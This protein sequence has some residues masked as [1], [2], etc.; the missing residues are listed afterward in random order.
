MFVAKD[1]SPRIGTEIE[2]PKAD[3]LAG[4]YA[5]ELRDLLEQRGVLVFKKMHVDDEEQLQFAQTL[6]DILPQGDKGVM[7]VTLDAKQNPAAD[8]LRGNVFWHI[9]GFNDETPTKASM[10]SGRVLSETGGQT[11]IANTYAAWDDL[12]AERKAQLDG[13]M[14]IHNMR[15]AQLRIYPDPTPQQI[16]DW[17]TN[18]HDKRHPLVWTHQSGRKSLVLGSSTAYI[19]GLPEPE[20]KA[21]LDELE[22]W[23]TQP[24]FVYSHE[25][26][27]GDV[28]IWDNTGV[29]HRVVPFEEGSPR[30]MHRTTLVG[31]EMLA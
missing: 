13:L 16:D 14:V 21:L 6:G 1:L 15:A 18:F 10:L 8:Y 11:Q 25:W 17:K 12:P 5:A 22:A 27:V 3:L 29:M 30:M 7:K 20:G 24:K 26:D 28:I 23:A 19:E 31:E 4:T 2:A 9:D